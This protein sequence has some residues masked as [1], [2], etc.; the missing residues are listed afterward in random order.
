V[1]T[2]IE[3][4]ASRLAGLHAISISVSEAIAYRLKTHLSL[5]NTAELSNSIL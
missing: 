3:T 5:S 4:W 2:S 1:D